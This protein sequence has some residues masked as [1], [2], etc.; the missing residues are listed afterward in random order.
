MQI[1]TIPQVKQSPP[2][3][4]ITGL[5]GRVKTIYERKSGETDGREW[6]MQDIV[7]TDGAMELK[8]T[9]ANREPADP[10]W[11]GKELYFTANH[12][13]KHGW[14][15]LKVKENK[16]QGKTTLKLQVSKSATIELAPPQQV[17]EKPAEDQIPGAE[18]PPKNVMPMDPKAR[19]LQS[20]IDSGVSPEDAAK[21]V[22][23]MRFASEAPKSAAKPVETSAV[24]KVKIHLAQAG[25]LYLICLKAT[26]YIARVAN[27]MGCPMTPDHL[28]ACCSTLFINADR[29]GC[30]AMLPA[31]PLPDFVKPETKET[32]PDA[33]G[34]AGL[35][36]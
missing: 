32:D 19:V 24:G 35:D 29:A 10:A 14:T 21:T 25:N 11:N 16:Y 36:E 1:L 12:S 33:T 22:A 18:V 31:K 6:T 30:I 2:D 15:G 26:E 28:Q 7:L 5:K 13:D 27:D 9:L 3:M 20:L 8:A 23:G 4:A 17:M 34:V